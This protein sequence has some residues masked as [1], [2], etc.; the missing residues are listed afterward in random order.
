MPLLLPHFAAQVMSALPVERSAEMLAALAPDVAVRL[1]RLLGE[2]AQTVLD[3]LPPDKAASPGSP[4][5]FAPET[6]GGLMD[7]SVLALPEDL[8]AGE[9]LE[10]LR[11]LSEHAHYNLYVVDRRH[12]LVGVLNLRELL[13]APRAAHLSELMVTNPHRLLATTGRSSIVSHP[14]WRVAHAIPV[15]DDEGHYLGAIRYRTLRRLE[16]ALAR[17]MLGEHPD[18][19][20]RLVETADDEDSAALL[21]RHGVDLAV[22]VIRRLTPDR[23]ARVVAA[24]PETQ[25]GRVL[26]S[27]NP[28][29]AAGLLAR[30][31]PDERESCLASVDTGL[32]REL[33]E[34][35]SYPPNTAGGLVDPRVVT[36]RPDTP[37]RDVIR[38]LRRFENRRI[39]DVS[40]VDADD[41]LAGTLALQDI[42]LANSGDTLTSLVHGDATRV[43][44]TAT[45]E[46]VIDTFDTKRVASLPV[47][48][49]DGR[50]LGV[51]RQREL[52]QAAQQEATA[53]AVTMVGASELERALSSP[54]FA[55]RK[56]LPWLQVNLL[57]AFLAAA[58]VGLFEDT[59]ARVTALAVL[60]PVVAEQS[61][62]TG[63]QA[64][65]VTMRGLTLREVRARQW[66]AVAIKEG[67][68]GAGNGVAV[69]LTTSAAV[70]LW[71]RSLPLACVIGVSMVISMSLAGLAGAII[72][73]LLTA[74]RASRSRQRP[75]RP[76]GI[77]MARR[78]TSTG[79]WQGLRVGASC[80][81]RASRI[82]RS[83][84]GRAVPSTSSEARASSSSS[85]RLSGS[86]S[87]RA[88]REATSSSSC[89]S[90]GLPTPGSDR[91]PSSARPPTR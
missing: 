55:V 70:Y 5:R 61:G 19:S 84:C 25:I 13:L 21:S 27:L 88:H 11:E 59:I 63:A 22:T 86:R 39:T 3:R 15:V 62:N 52:I 47:V 51:L 43:Q 33:R 38:R 30:L 12:V 78:S 45:R 40:L 89:R 56:R 50:L 14:G 44:A 71:S 90:T 73:M 9:A 49:F 29:T 4:L 82:G 26:A 72:P 46:E 8:A 20:A 23:A 83:W 79:S 48:D 1:A 76:M 17:M 53:S 57:T 35:A 2:R 65:A 32:A 36:F 91:R 7:A 64:L 74:L 67:L 87:S 18:E 16:E 85:A 68:A 6:A 28:N 80:S 41:Q 69:A 58:V 34:L 42:V 31:D 81:R 54:W 66:L 77:K 75:R 60:L 37:V 10:R 24:L